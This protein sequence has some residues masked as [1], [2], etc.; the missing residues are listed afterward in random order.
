MRFVSIALLAIVSLA[1]PTGLVFTNPLL[2]SGADPWIIARDGFYYYM[3][4]TGNNLTIWKTQDV[5]D[6]KSATKK[7][8]WTP[9]PS[10]PYSH[11]IWAP[12]LHFLAGKWYIYFAGDDGRNETHRMWVLENASPDPLG[13]DWVMKGKVADRS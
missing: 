4:T 8:V 2:P 13:G 6:L 7:V 12:E 9:P 1:A 3:Q 11:D 10:G 5:T